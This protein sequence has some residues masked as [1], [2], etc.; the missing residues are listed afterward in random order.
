[1]AVKRCADCG[2][3]DVTAVNGKE[4]P[5]CECLRCA[6]CVE[7]QAKL[8]SWNGCAKCCLDYRKLVHQ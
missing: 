7:T 8:Y 6:S 4:C 2:S 3:L 5:Y 1:M